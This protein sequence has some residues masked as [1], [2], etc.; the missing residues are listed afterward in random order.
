M[1]GGM[2]A[3]ILKD[4]A[5]DQIPLIGRL[6][7]VADF[8]DA[9]TSARAYRPAIPKAE[10]IAMIADGAGNALRSG[11]RRGV[12]RLYR[13]GDLLPSGWKSCC[14]CVIPAWPRVSGYA[15]ETAGARVA[16]A[17]ALSQN[18]SPGVPQVPSSV[19]TICT[20]TPTILPTA[21]TSAAGTHGGTAPSS[22]ALGRA[23]ASATSICCSNGRAPPSAPATAAK[24]SR[25]AWTPRPN[26]CGRATST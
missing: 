21:L 9:V 22:K 18:P 19:F 15:D 13:R 1:N 11:D 6:L 23:F 4:C 3:G 20:S 7:G 5:N 10:A 24:P 14:R 26:G 17:L 8:Y 2:A 25:H 16:A 12:M